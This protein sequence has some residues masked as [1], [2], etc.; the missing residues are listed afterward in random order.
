MKERVLVIGA[1]GLVGQTL[2]KVM[3][4]KACSSPWGEAEFFFFASE[5][6][7][8]ERIYFQNRSYEVQS[9]AKVL[10]YAK[11]SLIFFLGE[12]ELA[13]ELIPKLREK[14]IVID[15][16][17]AFR[18]DPD[19]PLVV[20]EVNSEKM[21]EHKNLIANPNCTVIPLVLTLAPLLKEYRIKRIILSSYQSVSGA[22]RDGLEEF[23]YE[24]EF[25]SLRRA[26]ERA[27]DSP[28]PCLIGDNIIPQI[29]GFDETGFSRE[30]KKVREETRKILSLPDLEVSATC[31]RVPITIGHSL[32][33]YLEFLE[34]VDLKDLYAA[35]EDKPYLKIYR[36]GYPT[37][38]EVRGKD[39]VGIGRVRKDPDNRRG[40]HLWMVADN[41]R[42][43]AATNAILIA[44]EVRKVM[45]RESGGTDEGPL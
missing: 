25:L 32:S 33:C 23:Y 40:V 4:E 30:E 42:R 7:E 45:R 18:L 24:T 39:W 15:N 27:E 19:V 44:Q 35:W 2:L 34:A 3:E 6:S 5:R 41:L 43:G 17:P 11:D 13:G 8:R 31:V 22:G 36:E 38:A 29:G 28:F 37:P 26:I 21:R 9:V 14:G 10:N 16:S 1:T 20:P 12:E